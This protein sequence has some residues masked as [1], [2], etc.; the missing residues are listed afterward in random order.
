MFSETRTNPVTPRLE[1]LYVFELSKHFVKLHDKEAFGDWTVLSLEQRKRLTRKSVAQK[2][3]NTQIVS[4][5]ITAGKK[6]RG[7]K[8]FAQAMS[9]TALFAWY[10]RLLVKIKLNQ[11][12]QFADITSYY[13]GAD[14]RRFVGLDTAEFAVKNP[15]EGTHHYYWRHHYNLKNTEYLRQLLL[16]N[17]PL[18]TLISK[19]V[20]KAR[21][22]H[23]RGK[24]GKYELV[25]R[26][27]SEERA[28]TVALYHMKLSW[29]FSDQATYVNKFVY[30]F[31]KSMLDHR[32]TLGY[33]I[34]LR[35]AQR[36]EAQERAH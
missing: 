22:K 6:Q 28:V 3:A 12:P 27:V 20:D 9:V 16:T 18:F 19:R 13:E 15:S 32:N 23:T 31:Y 35:A 30:V 7:L 11:V 24:L 26:K 29:V 4:R 17:A 21:Y 36:L 8:A 14:S 10:S 34:G 25:L 33:C 1:S 2:R 5:F